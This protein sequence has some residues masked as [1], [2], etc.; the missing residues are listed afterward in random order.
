MI[1]R[2]LE[3]EKDIIRKYFNKLKFYYEDQ[4]I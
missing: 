4:Y 2:I 3:K 1:E